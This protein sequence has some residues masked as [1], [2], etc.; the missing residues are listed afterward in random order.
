MKYV[1]FGTPDFAAGV[2]EKLI[3]AKMPP[4]AVICN[5]DRP[6]GKKRIITPPPVKVLA[7]KHALEVFQPEMLD[8]SAIQ[9]LKE[10]Q[11]DVFVV[12]A[13]STILK[14]DVIEIPSLGV[15]G[16]HP[17]LL[18][19]YRGAT[20]IQSVILAGE[21]ET[22]ATLFLIDE[23]VDHGSILSQTT[24]SIENPSYKELEH[25]LAR[26]S[27]K[28]LAETLPK[29]ITG[30]ITPQPQDESK[31][32][33]TKKFETA[34]A[35]ID[36]AILSEAKN[37]GGQVAIDIERK[38]RAFN[39]EP[40]AFTLSPSKGGLKRVKLLEA[41]IVDGKLKLKTTQVAGKNP[42]TAF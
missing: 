13:Y 18:P 1:F 24:L 33:L 30:S 27:G 34:D 3:E 10:F 26:L 16:V 22:G 5:P 28:L 4:V 23:K 9:K 12:A 15:I 7:E 36:P 11:A 37:L 25:Q 20:P 35:K 32:T 42:V 6:F 40:G 29:F 17:S 21:K 38:I 41:E 19:K 14:K 2:L 8:A 39:P 31:A